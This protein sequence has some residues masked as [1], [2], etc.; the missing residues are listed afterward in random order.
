MSPCRGALS[1]PFFS[2]RPM[3]ANK[4]PARCHAGIGPRHINLSL[5]VTSITSLELACLGDMQG[6]DSRLAALNASLNEPC[7]FFIK[8][9]YKN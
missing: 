5:Q 6:W 7:P 2:S 8:V 4:D 9:H 3:L 1:C